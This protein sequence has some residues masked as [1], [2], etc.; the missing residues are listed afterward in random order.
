M[1]LLKFDNK[2]NVAIFLT[3]K[4]K[5]DKVKNDSKMNEP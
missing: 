2:L 5:L 3:L 4:K 1:Y